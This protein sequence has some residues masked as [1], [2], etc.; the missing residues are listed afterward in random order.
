MARRSHD[1]F[2]RTEAATE[3]LAVRL[4]KVAHPG[5]CFLLS[6]D[7]GAGKSTFARAFIRA[8]LD[9]PGEEVPSP[10]FTLVQTYPHGDGD[11]WHCDL[12]RTTAPEEAL[13]LGLEEAFTSAICLVEWPENLGPYA[14]EDPIILSL[15]ASDEGHSATLSLPDAAAQRLEAGLA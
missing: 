9:N 7:I 8:R 3:K 4:A 11:I 15:S 10:T 2:L 5:D 1:I 12:Y 14:P 13:E 6:G